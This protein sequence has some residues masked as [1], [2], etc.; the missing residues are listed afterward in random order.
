[1]T[2]K[3]TDKEH[4]EIVSDVQAKIKMY[5][6]YDNTGKRFDTPFFCHNDLMAKRHYQIITTSAGSMLQTFQKEFDLYRLA[7]FDLLQGT[8]DDDFELILIGMDVKQ[9]PDN[10]SIAAGKGI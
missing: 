10:N 8:F 3:L 4:N 1:M 2:N 7:E 6:L 9:F 5:A